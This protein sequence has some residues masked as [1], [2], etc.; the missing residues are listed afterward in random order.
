MGASGLVE[1]KRRIKSIQ[2]TKKITKAMGFVAT[3]K[4]KKVRNRLTNND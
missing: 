1:I 3:S 4:L 2:S